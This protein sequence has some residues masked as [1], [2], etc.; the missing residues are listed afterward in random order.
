[1]MKEMFAIQSYDTKEENLFGHALR[2]DET[3]A[4]FAAHFPGNPIVPGAVLVDVMRAVATDILGV[5]AQVVMVKN[6]KFITVIVPQSSVELKVKTSY[7]T[8]GEDYLFK[9]VIADEGKI[10]AKFDLLVKGRSL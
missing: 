4:V 5:E 8:S 9:S 1:M 7:T 3:H 6:A 10:Y 2:F